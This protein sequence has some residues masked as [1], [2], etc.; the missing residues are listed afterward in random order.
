MVLVWWSSLKFTL[1]CTYTHTHT[2]THTH[3]YTHTHMHATHAHRQCGVS[4]RLFGHCQSAGDR[5]LKPQAAT[6]RTKHGNYSHRQAHTE[7]YPLDF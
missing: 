1:Y 5:A 6:E 3:A 4:G 7:S 2:R